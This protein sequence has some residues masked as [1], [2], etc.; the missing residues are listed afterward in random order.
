[1]SKTSGLTESRTQP[2]SHSPTRAPQAA[3]ANR[4]A[5]SPSQTTGTHRA[6]RSAPPR[7]G[8]GTNLSPEALERSRGNAPHIGAILNAHRPEAH[9]Q[10][11]GWH[12]QDRQNPHIREQDRPILDA[13]GRA[14]QDATGRELAVSSSER[15]A[16]HTAHAWIHETPNQQDRDNRYRD[17]AAYPLYNQDW[18]QVQAT[19]QRRPNENSEAFDQRRTDAM[20]ERIRR[21]EA[22][23]QYISNHQTGHAFDISVNGGD[24]GLTDVATA[25]RLF[26][27]RG[28]RVTD[29]GS[30]LHIDAPD[31]PLRTSVH[32]PFDP[33]EQVR[34]ARRE[35]A[36]R[37]QQMIEMQANQPLLMAGP[38]EL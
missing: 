9:T 4:P 17:Q 19:I 24:M 30:H 38:L 12:S 5:S 28:Y 33:R 25:R 34:R 31:A 37:S 26:E 29:E 8:D 1:M 16:Q 35:W 32:L 36:Q 10:G 21:R 20:A 15:D 14:Y 11:Q 13:V 27:Q 22:Q 6:E 2:A 7:R 3:P 23:H 18:Q